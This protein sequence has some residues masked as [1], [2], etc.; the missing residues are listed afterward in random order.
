MNDSC[1]D[2]NEVSRDFRIHERATLL[3]VEYSSPVLDSDNRATEARQLG[4]TPQ[5]YC[6]L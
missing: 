2:A 3:G 6:S 1:Y 4:P 5:Q